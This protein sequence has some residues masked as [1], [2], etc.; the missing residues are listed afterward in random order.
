MKNNILFSI[1]FAFLLTA[2]NQKDKNIESQNPEVTETTVETPI[3]TVAD[4]A[5]KI[6]TK[7]S[8]VSS[9]DINSIVN[10][11]LKLK[12]AL[13]NDSSKE[14]ATAGK[15]LSAILN[16]TNLSAFSPDEKNKYR[17]VFAAMDSNVKHISENADKLDH[18]RK[19]FALVSKDM[20]EL[21]KTFGSNKKLYVDYCP[22]YHGGKSGYWISEIK[23]IKNPYFGSEMISCGGVVETLK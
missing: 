9:L 20:T 23:E 5:V 1:A 10:E 17:T 14:A 19:Y 13:A 6:S 7:T 8:A 21:I 2:C 22:M 16:E 11:Y 4:S 15:K 12:N 3:T 18:Q